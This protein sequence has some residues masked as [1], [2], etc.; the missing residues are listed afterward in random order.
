MS[1]YDDVHHEGTRFKF[2]DSN[3]QVMD[4]PKTLF[5]NEADA[6]E[7]KVLFPE[8]HQ[9]EENG[10]AVGAEMNKMES[11]EYEGPDFNRFIHDL[12]A[13]E[14]LSDSEKVVPE[15]RLRHTCQHDEGSDEDDDEDDDGN[16]DWQGMVPVPRIQDDDAKQAASFFHR[17]R[18]SPTI[19][20]SGEDMED[21]FMRFLRRESSRGRFLIFP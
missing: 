14:E 8:E 19:N 17:H 20:N 10:F 16:E 18:N 12:D 13:D 1:I 2:F 15:E 11:L 5:Y 21:T 9:G 7:D 4:A 6:L 3:K